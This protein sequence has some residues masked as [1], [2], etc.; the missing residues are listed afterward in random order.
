MFW[1]SVFLI[2][3]FLPI[4]ILIVIGFL[5]GFNGY[6]KENGFSEFVNSARWSDGK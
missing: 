6:Q 1:L 4:L 5:S 3:L 2:I